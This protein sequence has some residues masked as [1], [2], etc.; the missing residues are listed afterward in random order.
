[1]KPDI[2]TLHKPDILTLQRHIS[3]SEF[4]NTE[5]TEIVQAALKNANLDSRYLEIELTETVLMRH[6]ESTIHTLRLLKTIGVRLAVDDFGTGFSSLSYLTRFP[7]DALKLD[8]SF[9]HHII[10]CLG[11]AAV[12]RAIISLANSLNLRVIAEGVETREELAFLQAQNC[13]EGQGYYFTRPMA[14]EQ[15]AKL[16]QTGISATVWS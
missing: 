2:S 8:R 9:V 14:A 11:D 10:D 4:R 3:S 6:A 13:D 5:F 7:I 15:F 16:V 1:M 12:I